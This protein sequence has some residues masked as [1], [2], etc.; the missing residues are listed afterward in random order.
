MKPSLLYSIQYYFY[1]NIIACYKKGKCYFDQSIDQ[2]SCSHR[3]KGQGLNIERFLK[4]CYDIW[5]RIMFEPNKIFMLKQFLS[6]CLTIFS[7]ARNV[8]LRLIL[9]R[10]QIA[11]FSLEQNNT[12]INETAPLLVVLDR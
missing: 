11:S 3:I 8:C 9:Y 2:D 5:E 1:E 7:Y 10:I 6:F 12:R 4:T